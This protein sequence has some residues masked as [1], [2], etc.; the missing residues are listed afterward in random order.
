MKISLFTIPNAVTLGNLLCGCC[1]SVAA[2]VYGDFTTAFVLICAA[3]VFDFADGAVA[4]LMNQYSQLGVQ[5]D[6]LSDAVSFGFAP[7]AVLFALSAGTQP[8]W[9]GGWAVD[10]LRFLIFVMAAF[11]ALR[12]AKFNIDPSQTDEFCGLPTPANAI[13]C[14]GLAMLVSS[15]RIALPLEAVTATAIVMAVLL[16]APL[17]M[18]SLKFHDLTW[19]N[20][21]LRYLFLAACAVL[22]CAAP[23][24]SAPAIVVMYVVLS[25]LRAVA[26]GRSSRQSS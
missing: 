17:R 16:V 15:G 9:A 25:V 5:L 10:V 7:A 24:Y 14:A 19:R 26:C 6:S 11:S 8:V 22:I 23:L 21:R 20:N 18:F 1:A 3:A 12:L 2:L 13:F 4:R